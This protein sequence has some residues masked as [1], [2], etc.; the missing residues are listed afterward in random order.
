MNISA[1]WVIVRI[2]TDDTGHPSVSVVGTLF[3]GENA[4]ANCFKETQRLNASSRQSL[5]EVYLARQ[6]GAS[7]G[8]A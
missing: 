4:E 8:E 5:M 2:V 6:V 7:D 3:R 1:E